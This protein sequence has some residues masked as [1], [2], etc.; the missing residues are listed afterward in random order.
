MSKKNKSGKGYGKGTFVKSN[1]F[2][3]PA[4]LSLGQKGTA[5]VVST[6]SAQVLILFLGKRQFVWNKIKKDFVQVDDNRFNMTYKELESLQKSRKDGKET[7]LISQ[8]RA[9][10]AFDELLAKGFIK[11]IDPGGTFEKH[12]AV[13][14]LDDAYKGWRPGDPPIYK[15]KKDVRRGYQ[16]PNRRGP[17]NNFNARQRGTPTRTSTG[18]TPPKDTHVNEGHPFFDEN[19]RTA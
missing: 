8:A 5:P 13:Y 7:P 15:R 10:R 9:T 16:D 14:A 17:G 2:L 3:S 19:R 6:C 12:K 11:V 1:L 18:D 4:F